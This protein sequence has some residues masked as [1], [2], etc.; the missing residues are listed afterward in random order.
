MNKFRFALLTALL[1]VFALGASAQMQEPVHVS[2]Q[3]KQV[4]PTEVDVIFTAKIDNGWHV[5]STG[6]P[7]GGPISA[8]VTT[9]KAEG[10]QTAGKLQ[11]KG[12]ELSNYDKLFEMKLRYFENA[13]SFVQR[14][15]ITGKTY[16]IKGYLEYG[17]CND[18]NCL[19][20]TQVEFDFKGNGPANAPDA[21][22]TKTPAQLAKE[23]ADSLAALAAANNKTE[24]DTTQK[25]ATT[26]VNSDNDNVAQAGL[27]APVVAE[28]QAYNGDQ[29]KSDNSIFYIFAMG[30]IGGLLALF[31]PC[32]WPI[33][34]MTVSFFLKRSQN[35]AKGIRDA[36][37]YGV[38]IIVIYV[39]LGLAVTA[40]F[41]PSALNSLSTNAVFNILF[42]LLLIVFALSFFGWFEIRLPD[43]WGNAVDSKASSTSG[44]LSIFLMAFTLALVS[45]SCT[46]PII[47]FLLVQV[48]TSGSIMG[49]GIGMLGFAVALALPFT[50]FALFPTW[51]KKAPKSGSW[52]NTIKVVLGF[53]ELAFAL[54][55]FSVADLAYGWHLLDREVFLSIW[56]ALFFLLGLYLIGRL[57]FASDQGSSDAMPV[58]CVM[59]GLVSF[60]FAIYMVPGLWGAP[61]KAVSAFAP[62]MNTQ[63]FNL[64]HNEVRAQYDSYEEGMAAAAAQGKPVLIDF[65]GFGCVNCR[66]MEAAVWTDPQV[67]D[68]L[69]KEYVLISLYV[70]DKKPL[71]EP[72]EVTENGQKRTL[73]TV[74]D[75]WSYL[76]RSKFGANA[77]PFYVAVNNEGKPIARSYSYDENIS[78]YMDFLNQGLTNYK[79]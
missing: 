60:A 13:V 27:W 26:A 58:P 63:D 17:A 32:V 51:L 72:I 76:Q 42:C 52:M 36:L 45:F 4:S 3:Q 74:G 69:T 62:P 14:Y 24:A 77:Q 8:T 49:P 79:K 37:T 33:I 38:S 23:K 30:F 16:H 10:A 5:Y 15:K 6:L 21:K 66:K 12:K 19:P 1:A 20:P 28:L 39:A 57:K 22:E 44:I 47:G 48:S 68:K 59:L 61:C 78:H 29:G 2:V 18:Q 31:T 56:I 7:S 34:P 75:K 25:A 54:K 41:G 67:A 65:T 9:E 71:P 53:I 35:K 11:A 64:Y 40:A 73:R 46:G 70:D 50:L 55:F 43:K